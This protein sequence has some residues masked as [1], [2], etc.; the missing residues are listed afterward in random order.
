MPFLPRFF[1]SSFFCLIYF[2]PCIFSSGHCLS[3]H[4]FDHAFFIWEFFLHVFS[5]PCIFRLLHT[6]VRISTGLSTSPGAGLRFGFSRLGTRA[7]LITNLLETRVSGFAHHGSARGSMLSLLRAWG[8]DSAHHGSATGASGL[9]SI[10]A[11]ST[12]VSRFGRN[13]RARPGTYG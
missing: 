6:L 2:W 8:S 13:M 11:R 4:F 12:I 5:V 1:R 9:I 10:W 3:I 7:R